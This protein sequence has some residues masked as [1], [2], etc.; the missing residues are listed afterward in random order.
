M[1]TRISA[2][3]RRSGRIASQTQKSGR[4]KIIAD[5]KGIPVWAA[6]CCSVSSAGFRPDPSCFSP[7]IARVLSFA[8]CPVILLDCMTSTVLRYVA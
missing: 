5:H 7:A 1:R 3:G 6:A 4:T 8:P 2:D